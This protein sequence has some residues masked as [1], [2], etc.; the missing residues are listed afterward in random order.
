M[1]EKN[2]SPTQNV[3]QAKKIV[4]ALTQEDGDAVYVL[5][6]AQISGKLDLRHRVVHTA[7]NIQR[8]TF[9][10][11]VD[12]RYCEFKQVVNLSGCTFHRRFNGGENTIY[13][14]D[15]I[16]PGVTFDASMSLITSR[17]EGSTF[18]IGA[19]FLGEEKGTSF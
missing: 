11:P 15:L 14:K 13:R 5:R 3:V 19:K 10:D 7:V 2:G 12:L 9:L 6:D 8:C 16:C 17:V 18:F 4:E 1:G